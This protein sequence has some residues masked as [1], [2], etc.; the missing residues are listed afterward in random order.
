MGPPGAERRLTTKYET[1]RARVSITVP[2]SWYGNSGIPPPPPPDEDDDEEDWEEDEEDDED[3]DD[4]E[5]E[6]EEDD[7]V[8]I[9]E[10]RIHDTVLSL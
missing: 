6:E 1:T 10:P 3:E 4:D 9:D 5:D 8:A 7:E 2:A